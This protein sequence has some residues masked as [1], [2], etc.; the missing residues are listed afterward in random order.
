MSFR[1][2][3]DLLQQKLDE[4]FAPDSDYDRIETY[5]R[6]LAFD[7]REGAPEDEEQQT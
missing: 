5:L 6:F 4:F 2:S 1:E 3:T 7:A